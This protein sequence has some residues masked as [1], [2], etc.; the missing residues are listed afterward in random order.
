MLLNEKINL[1]I[2]E[3]RR[4]GIL[5]FAVGVAIF[6]L[7][8][9]ILICKRKA[10]DF[11]A[12]HW[13][14][15]GGGEEEGESLDQTVIREVCEEVGLEVSVLHKVIKGF[16]YLDEVGRSTRQLNFFVSVKNI[17]P[18]KLTEHSEFAWI[19]IEELE[20]YALTREMRQSIEDLFGV[21]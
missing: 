6:D 4:E 10:D 11:L 16:D 3:G 1:L 14:L 15:P 18:I 20:A 5:R 19:G 2:E 8:R 21:F 17:S 13:E 9:R 12:G 7:K